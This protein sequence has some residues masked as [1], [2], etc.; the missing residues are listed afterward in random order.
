MKTTKHQTT[1][2]VQEECAAKA[3]A[4][5]AHEDARLQSINR[6]AEFEHANMANEVLVN[7]TPHPPFTPKPW[8]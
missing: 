3:Q 2:E 6:T 8:P 4:K 1:A 5:A 7:A